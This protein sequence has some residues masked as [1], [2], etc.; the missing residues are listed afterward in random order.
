MYGYVW[1]EP[2][3][4]GKILA[5]G[6]KSQIHELLTFCEELRNEKYIEG[7]FSESPVDY[8]VV[9]KGFC[10]LPSKRKFVQTGIYSDDEY[11]KVLHSPRNSSGTTNDSG[12]N[13]SESF[14]PAS[15]VY[16]VPHEVKNAPAIIHTHGGTSP[17]NSASHS[18]AAHSASI[19]HIAPSPAGSSHTHPKH[20]DAV[21]K[22]KEEGKKST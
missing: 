12:G 16:L 7:Y 8:H 10:K 19:H 11:D 14:Y 18:T 3:T 1:R 15:P 2:T 22:S 6:T 9:M 5:R 17:R 4:R 21:G 20:A 13:A